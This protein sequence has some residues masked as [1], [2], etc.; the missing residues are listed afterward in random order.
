MRAQASR[1]APPTAATGPTEGRSGGA[2]RETSPRSRSTTRPG[3][4]RASFPTYSLLDDGRVV[5]RR[6]QLFVFG[7]PLDVAR[8]ERAQR[9]DCET[10]AARIGQ[11]R[12]CEHAAEATPFARLVDLGVREGDP[13]VPA[14]VR[15]EA[16]QSAAEPELVAARLGRVDDI[17]LRRAADHGLE[18]AARPEV[19][20]QLP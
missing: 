14:P 13:T 4:S 18:L 17:G 8:D 7:V 6:H 10:P 11:R 20:K 16:D 9:N 12:G 2:R 15:R 3:A 1:T 5:A 19:L